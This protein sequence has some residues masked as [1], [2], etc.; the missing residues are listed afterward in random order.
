MVAVPGQESGI[1]MYGEQR[2]AALGDYNKDSRVDLVVTQNANA[3][4]LYR[5]V[6]AKPGL[7]VR[8]VGPDGNR[9]A[10]GATLRLVYDQGYGPTREIHG[11]SGHWSQDSAVQVMGLADPARAVWVRWPDGKTE[12]LKLSEITNEVTFHYDGQVVIPRSTK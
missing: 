10:I 2:G 8:L 7:R 6:R 11:G 5:N 1:K 4:K 12:S 9:T 3:T